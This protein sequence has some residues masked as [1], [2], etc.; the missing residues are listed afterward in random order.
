MANENQKTFWGGQGGSNWVEKKKTLDDMLG[1]FGNIAI[2]NLTINDNSN[3]IDIGCGSGTTTFQIAKKISRNGGVTGVDISKPLLSH[4]QSLN[5]FENVK[6]IEDDIQTSTLIPNSFTHAFSRFGVMFFEDSIT[7]F[8][9]IFN[10]LKPNGELSFICWQSPQKNLWQ[11]LIM[12][13]I[14]QIIDLPTPNPRD[15]GPFAFGEKEYVQSILDN[16]GFSNTNIKSYDQTVTIFKGYTVNQAVSEM[17][18]LNPSLSFLKDYPK[19]QQDDIQIKLET[20]Y[21]AYQ[22]DQGFE[23]PSSSWV[24]SAKKTK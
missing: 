9:N 20:A 14:K 19:N 6:F 12:K 10:L 18:M 23:F 1:P 8:R 16:A 11:T 24:V 3:I 4:A 21:S 7:A 17:L 22:N 15:P 2:E 5:T 13:E